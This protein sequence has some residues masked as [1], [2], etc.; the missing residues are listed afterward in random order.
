MRTMGFTA[1]WQVNRISEYHWIK[2]VFGDLI[3][4]EI[5]DG[6]HEVVTDHCFVVDQYLHAKPAAYYRSFQGKE[7]FLIHLSDET[8]EGGYEHYQHFRGVFRNYWSA[9]FH[10]DHVMT[11]PLGF[12]H[13][14]LNPDNLPKAQERNYVWSFLGQANKASRP[15]M[16]QAFR[17]VGPQFTYIT[18]GQDQQQAPLSREEYQRVL[19]QSVFV[20]CPMGNVNLE[21]WRIYEALECGAIPIVERRATLDYFGNLLGPNPLP[22][23]RKWSEARDFV[24]K[25]TTDPGRLE[26]FRTQCVAWWEQYKLD[27]KGR[28]R[29]FTQKPQTASP[30]SVVSGVYRIPGWH[31][32]ELLRHH[33]L[34]A[35]QKRI[36][37]QAHRLFVQ[38][39]LRVT[40]GRG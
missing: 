5:F 23:F 16:L 33:S 4:E 36:S 3:S 13:L 10:P 18:D 6:K 40:A 28:V 7:A 19:L 24:Q 35:M 26:D 30:K 25:M 38:R 29:D 9:V 1:I 8:Y 17:P 12:T 14:P 32:L 31:G 20:P 11:F 34:G 22:A 21:C 15:E 27:L 37:L 39:R 2:F